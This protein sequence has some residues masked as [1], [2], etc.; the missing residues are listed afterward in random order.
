MKIIPVDADLIGEDDLV[1]IFD[2]VGIAI[3]ANRGDLGQDFL[4][5]AIFQRRRACDTGAE[6]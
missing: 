5:V 1:V 2:W 4:F 6:L 3:N